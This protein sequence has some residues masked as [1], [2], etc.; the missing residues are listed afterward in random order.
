MS[1]LVLIDEVICQ[2]QKTLISFDFVRQCD[3]LAFT[4]F[5]GL[6]S[7]VYGDVAADSQIRGSFV[8]IE[9]YHSSVPL[10]PDGYYYLI[11]DQ[12][13]KVDM[14]LPD[15]NQLCIAI[16][17]FN[18]RN[19]EVSVPLFANYTALPHWLWP[20]T[21]TDWGLSPEE[22]IIQKSGHYNLTSSCHSMLDSKDSQIMIVP[23]WD[24]E[25]I[26]AIL[27]K[28]LNEIDRCEI[29]ICVSAYFSHTVFSLLWWLRQRLLG[30]RI[31][32]IH[33]NLTDSTPTEARLLHQNE[34]FSLYI[35]PLYG[36]RRDSGIF[37]IKSNE[38]A[39][40]RRCMPNGY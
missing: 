11:I 34:Q 16:F 23:C 8:Q 26:L 35:T 14:R 27:Q 1:I 5:F 2:D 39:S 31:Q 33:N 20:D 6:D 36:N 7:V 21:M 19:S 38:P 24:K 9:N 3:Y 32:V 15:D 10:R 12:L 22:L 30:D 13:K 25:N 4:D 37:M 17:D 18:G 29:I 28:D 40:R